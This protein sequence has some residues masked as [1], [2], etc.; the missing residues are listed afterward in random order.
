MSTTTSPAVR[1]AETRRACQ[2]RRLKSAGQWDP[3]RPSEPVRAYVVQLMD[4][5]LPLRSIIKGSGV[6]AGVCRSLLY[7]TTRYPGGVKTVYPPS[8]TIGT[9]YAEKLMAYRPALDDY[10]PH[11]GVSTIGPRRRLQALAAI[12]WTRRALAARSDAAVQRFNQIM[13]QPTTSAA[14]AFIVRDLYDELWSR[15]PSEMEVPPASVLR[16]RNMAA[17]NGWHGP[18]AWD[19]D[20][21]DDPSALPTTDAAQ[22]VVTEGGNVADRWLHGESVVLDLDARKQVLQHLFEWTNDSPEEIA[23][24]LEMSLDAVW[25]TWSRLKKKARD[26]GRREPWRRVYVP[27]ERDLTQNEMEEAA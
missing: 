10:P 2:I 15:S 20:T 1:A 16:T 13:Q 18:L 25:Q 11:A 8:K 26:E 9:E 4:T 14:M 27:R 5:G 7:G 22:P 3:S 21:I 24:R 17:R 19:D 12:G 6:P 23:A